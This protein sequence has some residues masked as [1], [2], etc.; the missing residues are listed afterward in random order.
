MGSTHA[1][2]VCLAW[3][4]GLF[5]TAIPYGS[6]ISLIV[7]MLAGL[8]L[9]RL[10]RTPLGSKVW[11]V[12]GTIA[13]LATVY[14]QLRIPQPAKT[15]ISQLLSPTESSV[16]VMVEGKV[17]SLP[18]LTRNEK[19]QFWLQAQAIAP[20]GD[21]KPVT[22]KVYT[23]VPPEQANS[24]HPGQIVQVSGSL[25]L[26]KA[27][28]NPGG[29][30]FQSYLQQ[31]GCFAGLRGE[32]V[33]LKQDSTGWGWWQIQQRIVQA[34]AQGL[35]TPEGALV[36]AMVLGGRA[37]NLPYEVKDAFV[38]VGLA[39]ALAA[40]GFQTS[41]ILGVVLALTRRFSERVQFGAGTLALGLF[42]GL[43]GFQP[44][45]LRAALMGFGGLVA[46]VLRRQ[47]KP[48]GSLLVTAVILLLVNPLWIWDLGFQLSFL[49]TI[50]LLVT[51][52][53][54]NQRLDWLPTAIA[55][56]ISVP[57][58]AYLWTLPLQLGAFGVLSPYSVPANLITTP[59]ISL[60]SLG[61][62]GSALVAMVWAEGG[63]KLAWLLKYPT[64][65]LI[66]IVQ[67]FNQLPG[68]GWAIGTISVLL[69][70][71]LYS[72]LSLSSFHRWWQKRWWMA[73]VLGIF[74]V[75]VPLAMGAT[76]TQ[77]IVLA[78]T[79]SPVMVLRDRGRVLVIGDSDAQTMQFTLLP[80]LQKVGI[81]QIDWAIATNSHTAENWTNLAQRV[82]IRYLVQPPVLQASLQTSPSN[83]TST[84]PVLLGV[85]QTVKVGSTEI[86][87]LS[88]EPTIAQFTLGNQTWLWLD[89]L[90]S[91]EQKLLLPAST[92]PKAQVLWWSGK[93]IQPDL[94]QAVQPSVAIASSPAIDSDTAAYFKREKIP[95]FVTGIDGAIQWTPSQG[96]SLALDASVAE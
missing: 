89:Q 91:A 57:I 12:A 16:Q 2:I 43:A 87:L 38:R 36:S 39:H 82:P 23:T 42:V 96:F 14:F 8:L 48:L 1:L 77:A 83:P 28:T 72:L 34:Q 15:D 24:L 84:K 17:G 35:G 67:G 58:A 76:A 79:R 74:L 45:V 88:M 78:T 73:L 33:Q 47:V 86:H 5:F 7:G 63:S 18:R 6:W 70:I 55:P 50:G 41:L 61:G 40:S 11:F 19:A 30:D 3:I 95:L 65:M 94:V 62:M 60:L 69:V 68:N 54:L 92:L 85:N 31:D 29:F 25:Y 9:H 13:C 66:A 80:Y 22:G 93:S 44:A 75:L 4:V 81:N 21:G 46:L 53:V 32:Q 64:Q 49:A 90:P 27:A 52:P 56:L 10:W 59:F 26:P 71:V 37:V 20:I 51:V